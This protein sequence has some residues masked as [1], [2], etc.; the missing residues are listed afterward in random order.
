M[1]NH[2]AS[3][4]ALTLATLCF[5]GGG[6]ASA[7][8]PVTPYPRF[9]SGKARVVSDDGSRVVVKLDARDAGVDDTGEATVAMGDGPAVYLE[10]TC[11]NVISATSALAVGVGRDGVTPYL[12]VIE[13]GGI[14]KDRLAVTENPAAEA[15]CDG[16]IVPPAPAPRR[17]SRGDLL[18]RTS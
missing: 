3:R 6:S 4:V 8:A 18:I 7:G 10:L 11:V 13:D 16:G 9:V 15:L 17:V 2:A 5:A 12:F 14:R 1:R